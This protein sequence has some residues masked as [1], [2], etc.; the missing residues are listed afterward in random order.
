[1]T[2]DEDKQWMCRD[3]GAATLEHNLLT[4]KNPFDNTDTIIGCPK[5]F[6]VQDFIEICDEPGCTA[7]ASCGFP[8]KEGFGGYRRTCGKHS[9]L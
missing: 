2:R 3:C 4:A 6:S 5:C 9:S 7:P 8:V 1:M